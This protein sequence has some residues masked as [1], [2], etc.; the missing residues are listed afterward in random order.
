MVNPCSRRSVRPSG[1]FAEIDITGGRIMLRTDICW[2]CGGQLIW[3][4]DHDKEDLMGEKGIVTH[5]QCLSCNALVEY[6]SQ[7]EE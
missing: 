1:L 3:Q 6:I 2:W 4:A 7:E 5:L